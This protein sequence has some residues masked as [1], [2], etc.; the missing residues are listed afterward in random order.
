MKTL[1][2]DDDPVSL[3]LTAEIARLC[4]CDVVSTTDP[5][6]A[7]RMV[8]QE[9]F[10][11]ILLDWLMPELDGLRLCRDIRTL[12]NGHRSVILVVTVRDGSG[13]LQEVLDAGADDYL[14][15]PV[16][17]NYLSVRLAIARKHVQ[18]ISE[19]FEMEN[20]LRM[21]Q[22]QHLQAEKLI[23]LSTMIGGIAHE[24]NNPLQ[25]ILGFSQ[26]IRQDLPEDNPLRQDVE[27]IEDAARRCRAIVAG[28]MHFSQSEQSAPGKVDIHDLLERFLGLWQSK[29][30]AENIAVHRDFQASPV[31]ACVDPQL[32]NQ[33][34]FNVYQNAVQAM[35]SG[36][37]LHLRTE[38][39]KKSDASYIEISI[40]DTGKGI[41]KENLT[42]VFDPFFTTQQ[43]GQGSG[44]GLSV[45]HGILRQQNGQIS[46]HSDGQ[47][48]GTEVKL[49][50]PA[51][52]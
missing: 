24:F 12:P 40:R 39:V 2:V 50:L 42:R 46:V 52:A 20:Q 9:Y 28:L 14:A 43:V 19:R 34:F 13:D 25:G 36:G 38:T 31:H 10:P 11:L 48:K 17:M 8:Q 41:S 21:L 32:M 18:R 7:W 1:I 33:V 29:L 30:K 27:V 45:C 22:Q 47:G 44:L 49:M 51:A 6:E 15:K 16:S 37:D 35:P 3:R 23:S 5:K 26:L 4:G